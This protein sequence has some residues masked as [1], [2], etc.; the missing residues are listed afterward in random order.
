MKQFCVI[1]FAVD[2]SVA[3]VPS[4][5]IL[6]NNKC[7]FPHPLPPSFKKLQKNPNSL[8]DVDNWQ[9][10]EIEIKK[11]Y[12]DYQRADAKEKELL[13]KFDISSSEAE[14]R[15]QSRRKINSEICKP[16]SPSASNSITGEQLSLENLN[17]VGQAEGGGD[18]GLDADFLRVVGD[19]K[20]DEL[21]EE[22]RE[23]QRISLENQ[24]KLKEELK[25]VKSLL[26]SVLAS[27][28][29][30]LSSAPSV[31][32]PLK[33]LSDFQ[34]CETIM[35]NREDFEKELALVS[36]IGG[37]DVIRTT[38]N[39]LHVMVDHGLALQLR[40]TP[41]T[42]KVEVK[43]TNFARLTREGV[44]TFLNVD[45]LPAD[46]NLR[47]ET[48][49]DKLNS[50]IAKWFRDSIGRGENGKEKRKKN[51]DSRSN[52]ATPDSIDSSEEVATNPN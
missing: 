44:R 26:N 10:W 17:G 3:V 33:L 6:E 37:T 51:A 19:Q 50:V 45:Q 39:L 4:T 42:G 32:W 49:D 46:S 36:R 34:Q 2:N 48:T 14:D 16:P 25:D 13:T 52:K 11:Q 22:L 15:S 18:N 1:I 20:I 38:Y 5:W 31:K 35:E 24:E 41:N 7:Y 12:D 21:T 47:K 30:V 29:L 28:R 9:V 40:W 23:F 43:G 27:G 8:S